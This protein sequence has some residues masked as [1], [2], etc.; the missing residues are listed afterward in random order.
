MTNLMGLS[1]R[2]EPP[3]SPQTPQIINPA[4]ESLAIDNSVRPLSTLVQYIEGAPWRVDWLQLILTKDMALMGHD[5][6]SNATLQQYKRINNVILKL[7]GDLQTTQ[8][9]TTKRWTSR[10]QAFVTGGFNPDKGNLFLADAGQGRQG[11]FEVT[12]C[13]QKSM[14]AETPWLVDFNLTFFEKDEPARWNDVLTKIQAVYYYHQD[15]ARFGLNPIITEG[16]FNALLDI[17]RLEAIMVDDYARWFFS[18][19]TRSMAVPAG[20]RNLYDPFV[21]DFLRFAV[22]T[23]QHPVLSQARL[24]PLKQDADALAMTLWDAFRRRDVGTLNYCRRTY[25]TASTRQFYYMPQHRSLRYSRFD[26]I[27]YPLPHERVHAFMD[28]SGIT[29]TDGYIVRNPE[30]MALPLYANKPAGVVLEPIKNVH[31]DGFYV[32]SRAF[33]EPTAVDD[34]SQPLQLSLF[35][36][37]AMDYLQGKPLNPEHVLW[38]A[39]QYPAWPLLERYYYMPIL[40]LLMRSIAVEH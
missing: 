28:T 37:H 40:L 19:E 5:A 4:Q 30:D 26:E 22:E 32:F 6:S 25:A 29:T 3:I 16:R 2:A 34:A 10:G 33:W 12:N 20:K 31:A 38:L 17:A 24:L 15:Y 7:Q 35:E 1:P 8:D 39:K 23:S 36:K 21:D 9:Q 27:V 18:I 14:F 13:E 11:C